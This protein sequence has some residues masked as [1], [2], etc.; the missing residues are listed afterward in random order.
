MKSQ[1]FSFSRPKIIQNEE[2]YPSKDQFNEDKIWSDQKRTKY[3]LREFM[4]DKGL[5]GTLSL[6]Y[7]KIS[8]YDLKKLESSFDRSFDNII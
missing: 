8:A 5:L 4:K 3:M 1:K 6:G 2:I 7:Y